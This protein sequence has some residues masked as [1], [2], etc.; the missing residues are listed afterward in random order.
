MD[1]QVSELV[2]AIGREDLR[3]ADDGDAVDV[4]ERRAV[5]DQRAVLQVELLA[6]VEVR[7]A[8]H[9]SAPWACGF[10]RWVSSFSS[11]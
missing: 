8:R 7:P 4:V 11:R 1:Q 3:D 5:R 10:R 2:A 9:G 6:A